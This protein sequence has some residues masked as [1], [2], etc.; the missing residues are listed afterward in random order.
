MEGQIDHV[1][2]ARRKTEKPV[3]QHMGNPGQRMPV[4]NARKA[5]RPP[6]G[7]KVQPVLDMAVFSNIFVIVK[8]EKLMMP[9]IAVGKKDDQNNRT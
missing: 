6:N 8:I 5:K 3:I 2:R 7:L 1:M 9:D 4:A